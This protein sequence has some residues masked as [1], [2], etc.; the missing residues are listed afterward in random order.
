MQVN[1]KR[2]RH[3][4]KLS[5]NNF[6][7]Q[8]GFYMRQSP[9]RKG[10]MRNLS[11][12]I[13]MAGVLITTLA[14]FI[15]CK[16]KKGPGDDP[17]EERPFDKHAMLVNMA[18]NLILPCFQDFKLSL[19]SLTTSYNEFRLSGSKVDFQKTK[20]AFGMS[21]LKYQR[22]S[23]FGFGPGEDFGVRTNFNIFPTK[24]GTIEA[25]ISS[26]TYD[27]SSLSNIAAKGF[28]ALDYLFF[29]L[30]KS[31]DEQLQTF[32]SDDKRKQY[33]A[34]LL[35]DMNSRINSVIQ[36]WNATYRSVFV[37]SL[38]S[39]VGSSI[40]FLVNQLNFELDYLKNS[41]FG[42]PLGLKSGG[43]ILPD[44][45][46]S[47]YGGQSIPYALETLA[48]IE[49]TYL[50]RSFSGNDAIGLDDYLDH[51]QAKHLGTSLNSAI[52][53]QFNIARSKINAIGGPISNQVVSNWNSVND[54]YKEL[55]K[56]LVLLKTDMPSNL[57]IVITYQ[58][59]DGD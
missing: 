3:H 16:K 13:L 15:A 43:T 10:R 41:K 21:Y 25:N 59:G 34:A 22:I 33:V 4:L 7:A 23:L 5:A 57:G 42:I 56:L 29:G 12:Y 6:C 38:G 35:S 20:K 27:L 45:C 8:F 48:I 14:V 51:L 54:A 26:G 30:N 18:D 19:D 28:P 24:P 44:N 50:G 40:G 52:K 58:D 11:G 49:N 39:D 37:N 32:T 46:E 47:Y 2:L 9:V 53:S 36:T 17:G 55:V 31:E 1:F